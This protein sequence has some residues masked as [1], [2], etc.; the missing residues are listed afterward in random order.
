LA[1]KLNAFDTV[2]AM[3]VIAVM[4]PYHDCVLAVVEG[5]A[6]MI[7][8]C[9]AASPIA[10]R[11]L[12]AS[13]VDRARISFIM[14]S[15]LAAPP[16][17][18][19]DEDSQPTDSRYAGV[20]AF[21]S[22]FLVRCRL[23]VAMLPPLATLSL[24]PVQRVVEEDPLHGLVGFGGLAPLS[25]DDDGFI[26]GMVEMRYVEIFHPLARFLHLII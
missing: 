21:I 15:L 23:P 25:D 7:P 20:T 10:E 12:S 4:L 19:P 1:E 8:E 13:A 26:E 14:D 24:D 3:M 11:S 18:S 9:S 2:A 16:S 17:D 5:L 6:V 22:C